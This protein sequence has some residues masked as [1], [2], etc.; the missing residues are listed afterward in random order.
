M[1]LR[2]DPLQLSPIVDKLLAMDWIGRLEEE[3]AQR[4]VLLCSPERVSAEPLLTH[5]LAERQGLLQNLWDQGDWS[6]LTLDR[7]LGGTGS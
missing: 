5:F 6:R 4:L 7:L 3:G 1:A 2:V